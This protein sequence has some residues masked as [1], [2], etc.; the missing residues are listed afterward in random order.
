M[1]QRLE[2]AVLKHLWCPG[3]HIDRNQDLTLVPELVFGQDLGTVI[4]S[5]CQASAEVQ[6]SRQ[7]HYS[8]PGEPCKPGLGEFPS[9]PKSSPSPTGLLTLLQV[10]PS[11]GHLLLIPQAMAEANCPLQRMQCAPEMAVMLFGAHVS[12]CQTVT[13]Q[14]WWC[15]TAVQALRGRGAR[16]T[17][18]GCNLQRGR[19]EQRGQATAAGCS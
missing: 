2:R 11:T 7:L 10:F 4:V 13:E 19:R 12:L 17:T 16:I 6:S 15:S 1:A 18:G 5:L 3:R 8:V 9:V 14:T